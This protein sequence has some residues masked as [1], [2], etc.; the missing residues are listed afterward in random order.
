MKVKLAILGLVV[1]LALSLPSASGAGASEEKDELRQVIDDYIVGWREGDSEILSRVFELEHGYVIW[2]TSDE[3]GTSRVDSMSFRDIV[4]RG[5]AAGE[6]YGSRV[7]ILS[8]DVTDDKVAAAKVAI[9]FRGGTY[10][11]HLTLYKVDHAW[12]IVAKTFVVR[13]D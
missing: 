6:S 8:L 13:R 1:P 9:A 5:K 3:N 7:E 10:I 12:K 11:D 2:V 4:A